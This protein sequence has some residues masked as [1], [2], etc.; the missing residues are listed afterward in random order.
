MFLIQPANNVF[1]RHFTYDLRAIDQPIGIVPGA[2]FDYYHA[3]K[4]DISGYLFQASNIN[5]EI[6]DF[7]QNFKSSTKIYLY[8]DKFNQQLYDDASSMIRCIVKD[9]PSNKSMVL[10][11]KNTI[12]TTPMY[13]EQLLRGLNLSEST[14]TNEDILADISDLQKLPVCL[15]DVLYPKTK[16]RIKLFNNQSINHIQNLGFVDDTEM[17]TMINDCK[18]YI[19]TNNNFLSYALILDKPLIALETNSLVKKTKEINEETIQSTQQSKIDLKD[20]L[21]NSYHNFIQK[22]LL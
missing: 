6:I 4:K 21:K 7:I 18:L 2:L 11:S 13:S 19:D 8:F 17:V 22:Y 3:H 9:E 5:K 15:E 10:K 14:N 1:T 20:I 16:M 12:K